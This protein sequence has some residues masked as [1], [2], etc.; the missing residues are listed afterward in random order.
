[1][2]R[3]CMASEMA[4]GG[5]DGAVGE[6]KVYREWTMRRE[7]SGRRKR[8]MQKEQRVC[9]EWRANPKWTESKTQ[10]YLLDPKNIVKR[11]L[12]F[13]SQHSSMCEQ[14]SSSS[15]GRDHKL[16]VCA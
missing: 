13:T 7:L 9:R 14:V 2:G 10:S 12:H 8:I 1:M 3:G 11:F 6:W 4:K 16:L 15:C 5:D